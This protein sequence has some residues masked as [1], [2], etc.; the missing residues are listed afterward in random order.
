M[1]TSVRD[2][3][4]LLDRDPAEAEQKVTEI[5]SRH[6]SKRPCDDSFHGAILEIASQTLRRASSAPATEKPIYASIAQ[7][8]LTTL[9]ETQSSMQASAARQG[10]KAAPAPV[11]S[12]VDLAQL[13]VRVCFALAD[14]KASGAAP[15]LVSFF[16]YLERHIAQLR[17]PSAAPPCPVPRVEPP[18]ELFPL[19]MDGCTAT[20]V[21]STAGRAVRQRPSTP[22]WGD[23]DTE[24]DVSSSG[25]AGELCELPC[26]PDVAEKLLTI[27]LRGGEGN[28]K[29]RK[30]ASSYDD[31]GGGGGGAEDA[32]RLCGVLMDGCKVLA[33]MVIARKRMRELQT[34]AMVSVKRILPL[35]VAMETLQDHRPTKTNTDSVNFTIEKHLMAPLIKAATAAS[36]LAVGE[37]EG[38]KWAVALGCVWRCACL[39]VFLA[40]Y[41]GRESDAGDERRQRFH[42]SAKQIVQAIYWTGMS[43]ELKL[44]IVEEAT[45]LLCPTLVP[46]AR[47]PLASLLTH[48]APTAALMYLYETFCGFVSEYKRKLA[49]RPVTPTKGP[50]TPQQAP[51]QSAAMGRIVDALRRVCAAAGAFGDLVAECRQCSDVGS[52]GDV[53]ESADL[54]LSILRFRMRELHTYTE[55]VL[56]RMWHDDALFASLHTA[57]S[58]IPRLL[59]TI[60]RSPHITTSALS[61]IH[62]QLFTTLRFVGKSFTAALN[63]P[64]Q[65]ASRNATPP[66]PT[67]RSKGTPGFGAITPRPQGAERREGADTDGRVVRVGV[68][69]SEAS[70]VLRHAVGRLR[71]KEGGDGTLAAQI[72]RTEVDVLVRLV[73]N[74]RNPQ[75]SAQLQAL[76]EKTVRLFMQREGK[77]P[78]PA[79]AA[80]LLAPADSVRRLG[81]TL[82]G[83]ASSG[84]SDAHIACFRLAYDLLASLC[85]P[86]PSNDHTPPLASREATEFFVQTLQTLVE[87]SY[88]RQQWGGIHALLGQSTSFL[89]HALADETHEGQIKKD[90]SW[91]HA[92]G[93][94]ARLRLID[95]KAKGDDS[96]LADICQCPLLDAVRQPSEGASVAAA[97]WLGK[98]LQLW[99]HYCAEHATMS[100]VGKRAMPRLLPFLLTMHKALLDHLERCMKET[101]SMEA[102]EN[103]A[104]AMHNQ[105]R[106]AAWLVRACPSS[107][108]AHAGLRAL[109]ATKSRLQAVIDTPVRGASGKGRGG[110]ARPPATDVLRPLQLCLAQCLFHY[111]QLCL[112]PS[113]PPKA[114]PTAGAAKAK[115]GRGAKKG[116]AKGGCG[117]EQCTKASAEA[118]KTLQAAVEALHAA[119]G[120]DVA[121]VG[122]MTVASCRDGVDC[123]KTSERHNEQL[124]RAS[125]E[126]ASFLELLST[127]PL[128]H[129][130]PDVTPSPASTWSHLT[131][132]TLQLA[133]RLLA[134]SWA[135]PSDDDNLSTDPHRQRGCAVV[136][137]R[138]SIAL[139]HDCAGGGREAMCRAWEWL[140]AAEA[141]RVRLEEGAIVDEGRGRLRAAAIEAMQALGH[142]TR[143]NEVLQLYGEAAV[144]APDGGP[145]SPAPP[146]PVNSGATLRPVDAQPKGGGLTKQECIHYVTISTQLARHRMYVQGSLGAAM[147]HAFTA[148][149]FVTGFGLTTMRRAKVASPPDQ[150]P[151]S[152]IRLKF[153]RWQ[154]WAAVLRVFLLLGQLSEKAEMSS[155]AKYFYTNGLTMCSSESVLTNWAAHFALALVNLEQPLFPSPLA[156]PIAWGVDPV[157]T[158]PRGGQAEAAADDEPLS[159]QEEHDSPDEDDNSGERPACSRLE[160]AKVMG[161][162]AWRRDKDGSLL[163][164]DHSASVGDTSACPQVWWPGD[165][166]VSATNMS[167]GLIGATVS[168]LR[169][170]LQQLHP[171]T[172]SLAR[173]CLEVASR[174]LSADEKNGGSLEGC[175]MTLQLAHRLLTPNE[176]TTAGCRWEVDTAA[177]N[178]VLESLTG[179]E[180]GQS[181]SWHCSVALA[182]LSLRL[183]R[184]LCLGPAIRDAALFLIE[185]LMVGR[186]M[187][188][189]ALSLSSNE[190][191]APREPPKAQPKGKAKAK[192]R[193]GRGGRGRG[194]GR[195]R[196]VSRTATPER[197]RPTETETLQQETPTSREEA[198]RLCELQWRV[199]SLVQSLFPAVSGFMVSAFRE[200]RRTQ[201]QSRP[202]DKD[203]PRLLAA[204]V[205]LQPSQEHRHA[206]S[207]LSLLPVKWSAV[208]VAL[209]SQG[210]SALTVGRYFPAVLMQTVLEVVQDASQPRVPQRKAGVSREDCQRKGPNAKPPAAA[211][212]AKRPS[213]AAAR[214]R[215]AAPDEGKDAGS[216]ANIE[217]AFVCVKVQGSEPGVLDSCLQRYRKI[218]EDNSAGLQRTLEIHKHHQDRAKDPELSKQWRHERMA[219]DE[220]LGTLFRDFEHSLL[221]GA[222]FLFTGVPSPPSPAPKKTAHKPPLKR[223]PAAAPAG[224]PPSFAPLAAPAGD[225]EAWREAAR[226]VLGWIDGGPSCFTGLHALL[227]VVKDHRSSPDTVRPV[228]AGMCCLTLLAL[229]LPQLAS[230]GAAEEE[231]TDSIGD[232]IRLICESVM[233]LRAASGPLPAASWKDAAQSFVSAVSSDQSGALSRR[234][235][236]VLFPSASLADFP[237]ESLPCLDGQAVSRGVASAAMLATLSDMQPLA[238]PADTLERDPAV[239]STVSSPQQHLQIRP[240]QSAGYFVLNPSGDLSCTE[241]A[242]KPLLVR[243][244]NWTGVIGVV[245]ERTEIIRQLALRDL[246]LYCGHQGGEAYLP[247]ELVQ[248]GWVGDTRPGLAQEDSRDGNAA[249]GG[250]SS[251]SR[252]CRAAA[253]LLL[254]CSSARLVRRV[255]HFEPFSTPLNYLIG[256]SPLALGTLFDVTDVDLDRFTTR[257]LQEANDE[258][259]VEAVAL[260]RRACRFRYLVG[261]AP[262]C[263]GVPL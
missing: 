62:T 86:S 55:D 153:D 2:V 223:A 150:E 237:F 82:R 120:V 209:S 251:A 47:H 228:L 179:T 35:M 28:M 39:G 110:A 10:K 24:D 132:A 230:S 190:V 53:E 68:A 141:L 130:S 159:C 195:G 63:K 30:G 20:C 148:A 99:T 171:T 76:L 104:G 205:A 33:H 255:P 183:A 23:P 149:S 119:A 37:G 213:P 181:A 191:A 131:I 125:L 50:S 67:Q 165:G 204:Q 151:I 93:V 87:E 200:F 31:A 162:L 173:L 114:L 246:Y 14:V 46:S 175:I 103:L 245:P 129:T 233:P 45:S 169:T 217:G 249:T 241:A 121:D 16:Q 221:R 257:L 215:S 69:M 54:A 122:A 64:S 11:L 71:G 244:P 182:A 106:L 135:D 147:A 133:A 41:G 73:A 89:A 85:L 240:S 206:T 252:G 238:S 137:Y 155:Y 139:A 203:P 180:K 100:D 176:S 25:T 219:L 65:G 259:L 8:C 172:P 4:A 5:I 75:R 156:S 29:R 235:P 220:Q 9:K 43:R 32:Y 142:W 143:A 117:W 211:P 161:L 58:A 26:P 136:L 72:L 167:D 168:A 214:S 88:D 77:S 51:V 95:E 227:A 253:A 158:D 193:G 138:L 177:L 242:I 210:Q 44:S 107:E 15:E 115:R 225:W 18:A 66:P 186:D 170:R 185:A 256:G 163:M 174:L 254:G 98:E 234:G 84:Q 247:G 17:E 201:R 196:S 128:L 218:Q 152:A 78:T 250:N 140:E 224:R 36:D 70:A 134:L 7:Q 239:V 236:V 94:K 126:L 6:P 105:T 226:K 111:A 97:N 80:S 232:S 197:K 34:F 109:D 81:F 194:R 90:I 248:K 145:R 231:V 164:D 13:W 56:C 22:H 192:A 212:R 1:T 52:V 12:P 262:V 144:V 116:T 188:V 202:L 160:P 40:F 79:D 74:V 198:S 263:F 21:E 189:E 207:P 261:S 108:C 154:S 157:A 208:F 61:E 57:L 59:D 216:K 48:R 178:S 124:L 83:K 42:A 91:I 222:S 127:P 243:Q 38:D 92:F 260:A 19:T 27:G 166:A 3:V 118:L 101:V 258:G 60:H 146:R 123:D 112:D 96:D 113:T 102:S 184:L 49:D 229:S 187:A 199:Q